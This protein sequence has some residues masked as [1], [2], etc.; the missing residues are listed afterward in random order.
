VFFGIALEL[1]CE[2]LATV[3]IQHIITTI[4]LHMSL[5]KVAVF[6]VRFLFNL[7]FLDRFWKNFFKYQI[8][9]NPVQNGS[10]V[11]PCGQTYRQIDKN[12]PIIA[13]RKF[14]NELKI[15]LL[16]E[17]RIPPDDPP[18]TTSVTCTTC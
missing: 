13:F 10:T 3:R 4:Q 1:L 15:I 11:V 7:N 16:K 5:S 18:L 2:T 6:I 9:L 14:A 12:K 8:L 17:I